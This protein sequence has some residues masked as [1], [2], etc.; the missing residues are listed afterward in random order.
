M[1][2]LLIILSIIFVVCFFISQIIKYNRFTKIN[3]MNRIYDDMEFYF[4]KNEIT[5]SNNHIELLKRIKNLVVNPDFLDIKFLISVQI[6]MERRKN[7][8]KNEIDFFDT[9]LESMGEEFIKMFDEFNS[10]ANDMIKLSTLKPDFLYFTIKVLIIHL[11][12]SKFKN[13]ITKIKEDYNTA[14][15][16]EES[17]AYSYQKMNLA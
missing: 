1:N 12:K 9:T 2:I 15:N 5:L 8:I 11:F 6:V 14:I 16:H 13:P 17:I 7:D 4:V 10:N 3:N